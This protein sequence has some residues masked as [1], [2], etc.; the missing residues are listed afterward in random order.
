MARSLRE[1]L[2][3]SFG[4][5]I[6]GVR[7]QNTEKFCQEIQ[8]WIGEEFGSKCDP[9]RILLSATGMC[10]LFFD[11]A[12]LTGAERGRLEQKVLLHFHARSDESMVERIET[13]QNLIIFH[14]IDQ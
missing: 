13:R 9:P 6:V 10:A 1:G 2:L 7:E 4:T 14:M 5:H 11:T 8:D 3:N 12:K